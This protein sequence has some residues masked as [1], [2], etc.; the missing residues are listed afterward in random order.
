[1]EK[2]DVIIVGA[3]ASGI[4]CAC[5]LKNKKVLVIE[6]NDKI[7]KKILVTGNGRCNF[8]N[9]NMQIKF[10]NTT[11]VSKYFSKFNNND[12][13]IYLNNI[14]LEYYFDEEGRYYPISNHS[15]SVLDVFRNE[16]AKNDYLTIKTN[17]KVI[18]ISK[19]CDFYQ[20]KT[21]N[22]VYNAKNIVFSCGGNFDKVFDFNIN[23]TPFSPSLCSLICN[24]NN[25]L[26]GIKQK[27]VIATLSQNNKN[28]CEFGEILFKKNAISG[29]LIFNLSSYYNENSKALLSIDLL[30]N[31]SKQEL[32]KKIKQRTKI[33]D[34]ITDIF[35]G[36]FHKNL[37]YSIIEKCGLLKTNIKNLNNLEISK[38]ADKIKKYDLIITGKEDNNQIFKG[39]VPLEYL[40]ENLEHK[41]YKSLYFVGESCDV[42]G[43]C[44]GYNLQWA[45]TSGMIVAQHLNNII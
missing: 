13:L 27:N 20:I 39:G 18:Q 10:F 44:G 45:F 25:N 7:G 32:C 37:G 26:V 21:N 2:Y 17:E 24:T 19:E 38:L 6:K 35:T 22:G 41:E 8:T 3:G 1:M 11:L 40:T 23:N 36:L 42:N 43:L 28:Y 15:S 4:M 29:I 14:G 9:K 33:F 34:N 16:L 12:L 5:N 30:P 31:F